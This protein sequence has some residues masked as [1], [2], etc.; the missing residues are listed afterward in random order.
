MTLVLTT[1]GHVKTT[2]SDD[3]NICFGDIDWHK[4]FDS[5]MTLHINQWD[6]TKKTICTYM[7]RYIWSATKRVKYDFWYNNNIVHN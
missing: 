5:I 7:L 2:T 4:A 6:D 3:T 1:E